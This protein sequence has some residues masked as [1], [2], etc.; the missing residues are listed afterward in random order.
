PATALM[1]GLASIR[2]DDRRLFVVLVGAAIV[3]AWLW[4]WSP[5]ITF[6]LALMLVAFARG[7]TVLLA[8][9]VA[10]LAYYLVVFYYHMTLPLLD[11]ALWLGMAGVLL[12]ALHVIL[13]RV[14]E[15]R[16]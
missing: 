5:G 14:P 6:G 13:R 8:A 15:T 2:H 10:A 16:P 4:R 3:L 7:A 1:V 11:K 9:S 12:L